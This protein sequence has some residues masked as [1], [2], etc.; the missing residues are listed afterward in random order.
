MN[1]T[2]PAVGAMYGENN[3]CTFTVWAP[4][5]KS[6]EL[7]LNGTTLHPMKKDIR[8]FWSTTL[9]NI[10]PGSLYFFQIEKGKPL[11]DPASRRQP[12]GVHGPSAVTDTAFEWTDDNWKGLPLDELVLYELH[13]GTFC[14][15][16][17][18]EGVIDKLD[19]FV[20]L[21]INAI[22]LMP[23]AH[24]PGER[25]WGYDG[26]YPYAVHEAYG[27][28]KGLKQL[29]NA[30]HARGIAVFLDVVYN[31]MGPEGNYLAE[32][33]PFFT[34]RYKT[35]WGQGVNFD[36]AYSDGVRN[37]YWRNAL[38][39]LD[40]FHFDGLRLD[41]VDGIRDFSAT[42]FLQ[43]LKER[44]A[45]LEERV[46]RKKLLVAELDLNNPRYINSIEKGGYGMD[47]QWADEFH[48][49]LHTLVTG[50]QNGYYVDYGSTT[51]LAQSLKHSYVHTGQYSE[52]RRRLFGADPKENPYSQFVV[53]SQNHDQIG[54]RMLG[55]RLSSHLSFEQLKLVAATVLLSPHVPLLFM[56][57]EYGEKNPFHYFISHTDKALVEMI[58]K[59]RKEEFAHF[60]WNGK[61]PDAQSEEVF[62]QST[63][64]WAFEKEQE[65][66]KLLF[67]YKWLIAFRRQRPAM[68][69]RIR[70]SM[71]V[72]ETSDNQVVAFARRFAGDYLL[73][74]LNFNTAAVQYS[75]PVANKLERIFD[76][77]A[78]DWEAPEDADAETGFFLLAPQSAHIFETA[79]E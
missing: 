20:D 48:H 8:G 4:T 54:N 63:L 59:G 64:S 69:G 30:A 21:G 34:D 71:H 16:R 28:V 29:V 57:E 32:Y 68:Q 22:E 67:Y 17:T 25:N 26:V 3:T 75:L 33:G 10:D 40:E 36:D 31:H 78:T 65:S 44:V 74:V 13:V 76:S 12:H 15:K 70:D 66:A 60:N 19:Y 1:Y 58:H 37:Y 55:D 43:G 38:Q 18:F 2:Y 11:P 56:G 79:K 42:H 39:W 77:S 62:R 14:K 24:S 35:A 47:G 52:F 27:G 51:H 41:A 5:K 9:E 72:F 61:L 49:A 45:E 23:V 46:E 7:L 50:E 73:I 53:F 6:V